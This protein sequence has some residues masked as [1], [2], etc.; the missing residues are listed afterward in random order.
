MT[1][2]KTDGNGTEDR[3]SQ[4]KEE[5]QGSSARRVSGANDLSE[6]VGKGRDVGKVVGPSSRLSSVPARARS[7]R[8][9]LV[10]A[11]SRGG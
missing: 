2:L 9:A 8:A 4:G 3:E 11:A 6:H 7:R 1:G 5:S 10:V